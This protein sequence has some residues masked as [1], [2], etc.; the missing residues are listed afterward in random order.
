M[1]KW[2]VIGAGN[3]GRIFAESIKEVDNANLIAV[4]STNKK[5][6]NSFSIDFDIQKELRFNNYESICKNKKIDAIYIS[7]LNNTHFDLIKMCAINKK[8]ILCE[9]PFCLNFNEALEIE[10]IINNN[11]VKFF[12]AIAYLSHPQTN[13]LLNLINSGEIGEIKS[14]KS[15][16]GFKIKKIKPESRLF[17]KKLGGGSILDIG[18]YPISFISLFTNNKNEIKFQNIN[19]E[20]CET[21]VDIVASADLLINDQISCK[22]KIS[23]KEY[24][25]NNSIIY[26]SKGSIIINSPWLPSK[27]AFLEVINKERYYKQFIESDLSVYANQIKNVTD[28]F[29]ENGNKDNRLFDISKATQNMKYLDTW[30]KN[31]N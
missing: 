22:I 4:A 14:I 23:L 5:R 31:I 3:M 26:G 9:K 13:H 17:N 27:K 30:M 1:I 12:E 10:K 29:L 6:L 2:G 8:H 24:F 25:E 28:E 16:F 21:N 19:G 11:N 15:S 20:I 7:T 18:C